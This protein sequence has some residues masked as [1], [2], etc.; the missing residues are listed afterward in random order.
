MER[1]GETCRYC[2]SK[3]GPFHIDHVMPW[4]RGGSNDAGNLVV[5]CSTCNIEKSD[6][7]PEE[8]GWHTLPI[9]R[10]PKLIKQPKACDPNWMQFAS[11]SELEDL[12][13]LAVEVEKIK[14]EQSLDLRDRGKIRARCIRRMRRLMGKD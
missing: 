10:V 3:D 4:S 1:D 7:T 9:K 13:R 14:A 8:M 6:R 2:G 11:Q 12:N 5:A